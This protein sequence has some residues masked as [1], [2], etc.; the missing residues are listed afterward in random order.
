MDHLILSPAT[1]Q[2][3]KTLLTEP[4]SNGLNFK[5]INEV[6]LPSEACTAQH[7]LYKQFLDYLQKPLPKVIFYI[8]MEE[9]FWQYAGHDERGLFGYKLEI[10]PALVV[11][12]AA[13]I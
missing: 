5:P 1:V 2:A 10:N 11:K 6:L 12:E 4:E 7:I 8:L 13:E 3:Y 9:M